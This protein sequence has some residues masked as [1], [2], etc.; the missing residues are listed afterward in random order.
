MG[1][2]WALPPRPPGTWWDPRSSMSR[3]L[4]VTATGLSVRL[5]SSLVGGAVVIAG[6]TV[7]FGMRGHPMMG[8][9]VESG[10][11]EKVGFGLGLGATAT[12]VGLGGSSNIL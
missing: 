11:G 1:T 6:P 8:S 4:G 9:G 7:G 2:G 10:V 3:K 12:G 5:G